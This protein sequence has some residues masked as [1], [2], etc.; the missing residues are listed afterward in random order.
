MPLAYTIDPT[1]RIVTITGEYAGADEWR[2]LLTRVLNDPQRQAGFGFL[3]DLRTA[4]S[5]VTAATVVG[6][7]DVIREFWPLLEPTGI[8]VITP[9][10]VDPAALTAHAIADAEHVALRV[11]RSYDDAL[12]WLRRGVSKER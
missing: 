9:L 1:L 5:P 6:V 10:E 2:S 12:E 11:F 4:T 8:A 7:M 3:R